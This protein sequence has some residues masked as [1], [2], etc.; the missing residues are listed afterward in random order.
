M[1]AFVYWLLLLSD[2]LINNNKKM[3]II[4]TRFVVRIAII[5]SITIWNFSI[6]VPSLPLSVK[7]NILTSSEG[8]RYVA[9][10]K[11]KTGVTG[12]GKGHLRI[13][14]KKLTISLSC[15]LK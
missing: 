7:L 10:R 8:K 15:E 12:V 6:T 9:K 5:F 3:A 1:I 11:E 13:S 2:Y 14:L 4:V